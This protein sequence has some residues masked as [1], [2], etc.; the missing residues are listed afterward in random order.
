[1]TITAGRAERL[2]KALRANLARRKAQ[3]RGRDAAH[4][5]TPERALMPDTAV[6]APIGAEKP[7][8]GK[9]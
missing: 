7:Q 8:G 1:M 6:R 9:A 3:A 2:A 5:V 4:E